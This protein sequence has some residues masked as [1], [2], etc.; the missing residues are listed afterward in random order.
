[1]IAR[2][3][4]LSKKTGKFKQGRAVIG[5]PLI[6]RIIN[7]KRRQAGQPGL[8]GPEMQ[9][10]EQKFLNARLRAIGS[11][12]AGWVA[13]IRKLA[14]AAKQAFAIERTPRVKSSGRARPAVEGWDPVAELEYNLAIRKKE[15]LQIDPRVE[16][17]LAAAFQTELAS[18]ETHILK[19]LQRDADAIN[20]RP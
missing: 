9:R 11:L 8:E 17:A 13:A 5:G 4:R 20:A 18:M 16:T 2:E 10:A 19:R 6:A 1:V 3:T 12:R 14:A 7:K 15:A